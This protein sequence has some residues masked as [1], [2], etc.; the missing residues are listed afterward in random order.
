VGRLCIAEAQATLKYKI[1]PWASLRP[2][3]LV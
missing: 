2:S 1:A 3:W